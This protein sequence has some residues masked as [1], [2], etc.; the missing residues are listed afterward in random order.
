MW[1]GLTGNRSSPRAGE[2][3][4]ETPGPLPIF[5]TSPGMA[6]AAVAGRP[7]SVQ[8]RVARGMGGTRNPAAYALFNLVLQ[9]QGFV[10]TSPSKDPKGAKS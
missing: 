7:H 6:K 10:W 3:E 5:E 4:G 2:D 9:K 1:I 8:H